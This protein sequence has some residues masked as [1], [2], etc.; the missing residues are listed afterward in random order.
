MQCTGV[1]IAA[2]AVLLAS[3]ALAEAPVQLSLKDKEVFLREAKILVQ[4]YANKGITSSKRATLSDG[5]ITHDAHVQ[6]IDES[7]SSFQGDR[8]VE[9]NFRDSYKF[10]IAGYRLATLLGLEHMVPPSVERK[11]SGRTSAIT[12][13]VD[14]VI[15]DEGQRLRKKIDAPDPERWNRQMHIVRVFDQLI[16]NTDRNLG[17]LLICK[18]WSLQM[19]DHTR[20]FRIRRDLHNPKNLVMCDRVL[21]ER[22]RRLNEEELTKTLRPYVTKAEIEGLLA[23]RD[24]I[25]RTFDERIKEKGEAAVLFDYLPAA[26]A[27]P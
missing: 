2:A 7:K 27:A 16:F 21:L 6:S 1:R 24:T 8:S 9:L 5:K 22:M 20:A 15:M 4:K 10:N 23:R 25:V 18:D 17:N 12:W 11:V 26:S 14:D 19:I 13:W 3:A